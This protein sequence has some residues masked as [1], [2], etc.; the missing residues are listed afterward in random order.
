[1]RWR[2]KCKPQHF[3]GE[4]WSHKR[5]RNKVE[6]SSWGNLLSSELEVFSQCGLQV[7]WFCCLSWP[8]WSMKT[9]HST[10]LEGPAQ[11]S[12]RVM[13]AEPP[14]CSQ[15]LN[16]SGSS[17]PSSPGKQ[18]RAVTFVLEYFFETVLNL[19]GRISTLCTFP[20]R[21]FHS[22]WALSLD[23]DIAKA[24]TKGLSEWSRGVQACLTSVVEMRRRLH[25]CVC[26]SC[27]SSL[28]SGCWNSFTGL[29]ISS[30]TQSREREN[31]A[32]RVWPRPQRVCTKEPPLQA[33]E[34]EMLLTSLFWHYPFWAVLSRCL[35]LKPVRCGDLML[36]I[37][38]EA[39]QKNL[40]SLD[41]GMSSLFS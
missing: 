31:V 41:E 9:W 22:G 21:I 16:P 13:A 1:M 14:E 5:K 34:Q 8:T 30:E 12:G 17:F 6:V 11:E 7:S 23:A 29:Q 26:R 24:A 32:L 3:G 39:W 20:T 38:F 27:P 19:W 40:I 36:Q 33:R 37:S 35:W 10:A 25:A 2:K 15:A 18:G 4:W 28:P